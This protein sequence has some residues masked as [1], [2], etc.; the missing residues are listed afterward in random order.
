MQKGH[1]KQNFLRFFKAFYFNF[2][3]LRRSDPVVLLALV[4]ALA[5]G[6]GE[7]GDVNVIIINA[8]AFPY[9]YGRPQPPVALPA[10]G[11]LYSTGMIGNYSAVPYPPSRPFG[12]RQQPTE[13][14]NTPRQ[15]DRREHGRTV[16]RLEDQRRRVRSPD[17]WK[18]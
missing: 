18:R 6:H 14:D 16:I 3:I 7:G 10:R 1:S 8:P 2:N 4:P 17:A 15:E 9:A 13:D 5:A 12:S 11:S